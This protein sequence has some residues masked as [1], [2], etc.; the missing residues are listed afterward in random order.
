MTLIDEPSPNFEKGRE[1]HQPTDIV[2][3]WMDSNLESADV[4]FDN[5]ANQVSAHYGIEDTNEYHFVPDASTAWHAGTHAENLI[6]IGI[7]HSATPTRPASLATINTSINRITTLIKT[8][9][10]L[11]PDRIYPHNR[12]IATQCPGSLPVAYIIAHVKALL[13][14]HPTNKPVVNPPTPTPVGNIPLVMFPLAAGNVFGPRTGPT[15]QHSGYA[16][17]VDH[18]GMA[19]WQTAMKARGWNITV[20]GYYGDQTANVCRQFQQ[21]KGLKV[22]GLIGLQTW[23]RTR[24]LP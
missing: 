20:D 1:G 23:N 6:S 24:I 17:A 18:N 14:W 16:S 10:T 9:P 8:I 19:A 13:A 12:F 7:E 4:E 22:D 2:L 11:S 15:W 5:T 3:H 21:E